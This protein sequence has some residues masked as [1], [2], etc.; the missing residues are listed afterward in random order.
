MHGGTPS[1]E[2]YVAA[3]DRALRVVPPETFPP[4]FDPHAAVAQARDPG[5]AI[6]SPISVMACGRRA[7]W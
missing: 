5:F 4:G 6:L 7:T 2:W 3:L 1:A